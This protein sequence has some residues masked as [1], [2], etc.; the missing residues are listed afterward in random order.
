M[1]NA[2]PRKSPRRKSGAWSKLAPATR[3]RYKGAG[4]TRQDYYRGV[5]LQA[6]RG[7]KPKPS[8]DAAPAAVVERVIGGEGTM[9]DLDVLTDWAERLAGTTFGS[10]LPVNMSADTKAALSQLDLRPEQWGRVH[11][12]PAG[13]DEPWEMIVTPKGAPLNADG[14]SPYDRSIL[15]P[16]GG[17]RD[18]TGAREVLDWLTYGDDVPDGLEWDVGGTL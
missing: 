13:D 14:T 16:G 2:R 12:V 7:H 4:I 8:P 17:G 15:I 6:A 10:W 3:K 1:A 9:A 11:F 5:S 18:T